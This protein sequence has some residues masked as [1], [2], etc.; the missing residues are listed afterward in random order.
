M[1]LSDSCFNGIP[2]AAG[3]K[4]DLGE[5]RLEEGTRE[6]ALLQQSGGRWPGTKAARRALRSTFI[7]SGI[8]PRP[9]GH[10]HERSPGNITNTCKKMEVRKGK[11][12]YTCRKPS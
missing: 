6:R 2:R 8:S 4:T 10:H 9:A 1:A 7:S 5:A 3:L 12:A 11:G